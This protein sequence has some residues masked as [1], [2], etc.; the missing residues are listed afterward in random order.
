LKIKYY[1]WF[2]IIL[3]ILVLY[4][5]EASN[6]I[7]LVQPRYVPIGQAGLHGSGHIYFVP[8][9]EFPKVVL[10]RFVVFY[11]NKYGM[12]ISILPALPLPPQAFNEGR[13]QFVAE[14]L[15]LL[16]QQ[17]DQALELEPGSTIIG[18]TDRD[19]YIDQSN[20]RYAFSFRSGQ[21]A[22]VSSA[23]MDH[24]FMGVWPIDSDWRETRLRKM[25]TKDIGIL[26]YQ[27]SLSSN[28]RS[29]IFGRVGGPQELDFMGEDL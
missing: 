18:L 27:L 28:C 3:F 9:A 12:N 13:G 22:I 29:P 23:R 17:M 21:L 14:Q 2:K 11:R 8:L 20:W 4:L 7:C 24:R 19:I 26:Y 6:I 25:V 1:A 16:L 10:E 15:I 5:G